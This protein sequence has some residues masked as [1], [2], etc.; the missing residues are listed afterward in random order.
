VHARSLPEPTA[1][2]M[3]DLYT[4]MPRMELVAFKRRRLGAALLLS[5]GRPRANLRRFL[6]RFR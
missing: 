6:V 5:A 2:V 3:R 1:D 4:R